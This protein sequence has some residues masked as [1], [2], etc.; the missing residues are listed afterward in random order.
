M[1]SLNVTRCD[2]A[3]R[4]SIA[5]LQR[6]AEFYEGLRDGL[7]STEKA[8]SSDNDDKDGNP[9]MRDPEVNV[10]ERSRER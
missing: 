2:K 4:S 5:R 8:D 3:Q 1:M 9:D 6:G 7:S 10:E